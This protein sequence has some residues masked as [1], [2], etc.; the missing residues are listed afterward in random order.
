MPESPVKGWCRN[1]RAR[2]PFKKQER[3]Y[4]WP[5]YTGTLAG[6]DVTCGDQPGQGSFDGNKGE[7]YTY[8]KYNTSN[9]SHNVIWCFTWDPYPFAVKGIQFDMQTK[10]SGCSWSF[11]NMW[12]LYKDFGTTRTARSG[13]SDGM[14]FKEINMGNNYGDHKSKNPY[15]KPWGFHKNA[16]ADYSTSMTD[17]NLDCSKA[18]TRAMFQGGHTDSAFDTRYCVGWAGFITIGKTAS[19]KCNQGFVFDNFYL[20]PDPKMPRTHSDGQTYQ[21]VAGKGCLMSDLE[22]GERRVLLR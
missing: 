19:S 8:D 13:T 22:N 7:V 15:D 3:Q 4:F 12:L 11:G 14:S 18:G 1:P 17:G 5:D 10:T 16:H 21:W 20:L 2:F 6:R 9:S